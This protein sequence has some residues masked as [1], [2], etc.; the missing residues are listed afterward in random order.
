M[1]NYRTVLRI[2]FALLWL[3]SA[4]SLPSVRGSGASLSEISAAWQADGP[5]ATDAFGPQIV[6]LTAEDGAPNDALGTSLDLD[7]D[8]LVAGAPNATVGGNLAQGAAYVFYR[9]PGGSQPW[10]FITK[11]TAPDGAEDDSF[12]TSVTVDGDVIAVGADGATVNANLYQGAVYIYYRNP[13]DP[14][15]WDYETK[16]SSSDGQFD[17]AFGCSAA[18][19]GN[20]LV[21]GAQ[22]ADVVSVDDDQGA[23]YVFDRTDGGANAWGE[24]AKL[25]ASDGAM[26]DSFGGS[27]DISGKSVVIGAVYASVSGRTGQGTAYVFNQDWGGG[28]VW[29]QVKKLEAVESNQED[30]FGSAVAID[31]DT[32]V[33]GADNATFG[34]IPASGGAYIFDRSEGGENN[35]GEVVQ[36]GPPIPS[37]PPANFDPDFG[38]SV[39]ILGNTVMVGADLLDIGSHSDQ[40]AAYVYERNEGGPDAWG[41]VTWITAV[42]GAAQDAFGSRVAVGNDILVGSAPGA[43]SGAGAVYL[44]RIVQFGVYLPVLRR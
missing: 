33:V 9:T 20:L 31:G 37:E 42:G 1:K 13:V 2:T 12:G 11:L 16:I 8:T 40:G 14:D 21:V 24:V 39:A 25:T 5:L 41:Q 15:Q 18:L 29:G 27:L 38:V 19:D 44:F 6:R 34:T 26:N 7:G 28:G 30:S 10:T 17:D 43:S 35:W 3:V 22:Y 32:I 36:I 4:A 23:A